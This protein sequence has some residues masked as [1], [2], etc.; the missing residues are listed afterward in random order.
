MR[1]SARRL[2]GQRHAVGKLSPVFLY[3]TMIDKRLMMY[4]LTQHHEGLKKEILLASR[5]ICGQGTL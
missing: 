2:S 4:P 3:A 1:L 5:R